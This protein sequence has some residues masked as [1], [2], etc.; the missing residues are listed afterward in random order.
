MEKFNVY[1]GSKLQ[2]QDYPREKIERLMDNVWDILSDVRFRIQNKTK[3]K[4][5]D[6]LQREYMNLYLRTRHIVG[7]ETNPPA[8]E[9]GIESCNRI[10]DYLTRLQERGIFKVGGEEVK[11]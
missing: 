6:A 11:I 7:G 1:D 8:L 5:W 4:N 9:Y 2:K 10:G 3:A